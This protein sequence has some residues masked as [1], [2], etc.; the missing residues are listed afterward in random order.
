MKQI[1]STLTLLLLAGSLSA[2]TLAQTTLSKPVVRPTATWSLDNSHSNVQFSV[3]HLVISEVNG[4]F[5]L[6]DG[7]MEST[8]ADF[9]DAKIK[10]TI[11]INSINTD[12]EMRDGHL[13]GDDFFNAASFPKATFVSKSFVKTGDKTYKLTGDLTIRDVTKTVVFDV[14]YGGTV[15]DPY[16]NTKAGFKASTTINR[17][18]YNLKWNA[19]TEAGAVVG[20]DVRINCNIQMKQN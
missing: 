5:K 6:F 2:Q 18:D 8:A 20:P 1:L 12:N 11:D 16:G 9:T 3:T 14:T 15:K 17:F 7:T 10:F 4:S 13:K 19:L